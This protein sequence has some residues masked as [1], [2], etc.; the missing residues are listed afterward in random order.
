MTSGEKMNVLMVSTALQGHI[1]PILKLAKRFIQK[2]LHVTLITT[3]IVRDRMLNYTNN[4]GTI[5]QQEIQFEFFSDGLTLDFD[6]NKDKD[7]F[8]STLRTIGSK[9]M[10]KLIE[11][12]IRI[13][14]H[15]FYSCMIV[16]PLL[17]WAIDIAIDHNI[18]SALLWIQ[19]CALYLISYHYHNNIDLFN[20]L[21]DPNEI[22]QLPGLPLLE[23][24]DLPSY[25]LSYGAPRTKQVMMELYHAAKNTKWVFATSNYDLEKEIIDYMA[26]GIPIYPIGPLVSQFML[27]ENETI[28]INM[29][30]W[31]AEDSC[32][33][34]LDNKSCSSVIYISFGSV[35]VL[36]QEQVNNIAMALKNSEKSFLWVIKPA[37][38]GSED[39]V[40]E[41]PQGFLEETKEKG[42]V[43]KWCNQEK[44]LMHHAVACF[45]THCGW[46]SL[47]ETIV[48]GVP[49]IGYPKWGDQPTNAKVI[50]KKFQNGV[51]MNF[52]EDGV[53]SVE[54]IMRS[55]KEVMEGSSAEEMKKR[56]LEMKEEARKA[57]E[58]GGSSNKNIDQFINDLKN[59]E[60]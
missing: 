2:G 7:K 49:V 29:N 14:G 39:E 20:D 9:N 8:V 36:S 45:M 56:A 41:L 1:N 21:E 22:V 38:I 55:I 16:D 35:I 51:V 19:P 31:E 27:G 24:K 47:L 50:L 12:L 6:R 28:G 13:N 10:S 32:I 42:L 46:N 59:L 26:S 37:E 43:V 11:N 48:A 40:P 33:G 3:E 53:A 5:N 23:V 18:P 57:L 54:E 17:P 4:Y 52:G 60:H 58:E 30:M 34:W 25:T 44:V 15:K